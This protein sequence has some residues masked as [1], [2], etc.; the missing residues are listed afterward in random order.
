MTLVSSKIKK[1]RIIDLIKWIEHRFQQSGITNSKLETE[2]LIC[3]LL[4]CKR[5]DLY[6]NF[7]KI[8]NQ[9]ELCSLIFSVLSF[10]LYSM[11]MYP[12]NTLLFAFPELPLIICE[13][14]P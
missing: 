4:N 10:T 12:I 5:I 14:Y 13:L 9:N 1:W 11:Q 6:V 2:W 7:E 8:L 3:D